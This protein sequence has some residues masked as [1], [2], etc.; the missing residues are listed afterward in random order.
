MGNGEIR[1]EEE[2][3]WTEIVST[4]YLSPFPFSLFPLYPSLIS[5]DE[6]VLIIQNCD[7][8]Y[9]RIDSSLSLPI[10]FPIHTRLRYKIGKKVIYLIKNLHSTFRN[11]ASS[12]NSSDVDED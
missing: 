5:L 8:N 7:V 10:H 9:E 3:G 4:S 6:L 2:V 11:R 1:Y 12:M